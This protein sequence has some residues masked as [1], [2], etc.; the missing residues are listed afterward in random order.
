MT[1][2]SWSSWMSSFKDKDPDAGES[3][4]HK[5]HGASR[6][7]CIVAYSLLSFFIVI[8]YVIVQTEEDDESEPSYSLLPR[9]PMATVINVSKTSISNVSNFTTN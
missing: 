9:F 2:T 6:A 8:T 7:L 3:N 5:C 1:V 4:H